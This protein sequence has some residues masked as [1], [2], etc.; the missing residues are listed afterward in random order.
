MER[1]TFKDFVRMLTNANTRDEV[2]EILLDVFDEERRNHINEDDADLLRDLAD[3][4][5]AYNYTPG[6]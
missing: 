1:K 4:L 3:S 6:E 5:A 2:C